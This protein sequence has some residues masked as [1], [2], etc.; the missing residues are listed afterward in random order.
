M[1][2]LLV[3]VLTAVQLLSLFACGGG[4]KK[5][6]PEPERVK[7]EGW[8]THLT[9][10]IITNVAYTGEK[11]LSYTVYM[12]R[13]ETEGC[14]LAVLLDEDV[15]GAS[16]VL[17]SGKNDAIKE[18]AFILNNTHT[19]KRKEWTDSAVPYYG[20]RI[21]QSAGVILPFVVEF[22]TTADTPA[23]D[24][25][26]VYDFL[27]K[28]KNSLVRFNVTV[29]VWDIVLSE[30]KSFA[31]AAGVSGHFIGELDI[32]SQSTF[33][34]YYELLLQHN[35]SAYSIPYDLLDDKADEYMSD[36]R[37]TSFAVGLVVVGDWEDEKI[38]R[39][40][41]KLKSNPVWL[42]KAYFYIIDEPHNEEQ[43]AEY[44]GYC[45]RL[46]TLCPEIPVVAPFYTNIQISGK[47]ED[48]VDAMAGNTMLWC[49]K[50]CL[51]DDAKSYDEFLNYTPEKSFAERMKEFQNEGDVIWSYVCNDPIMPYAQLYIDTPGVVQRLM[52]WQHYQ[53]DIT[54][55]LYWSTNWWGTTEN[56]VNP[57]DTPNNGMSDGKGNITYGEGYL[58]YP[59]KRHGGTVVPSTRLKILRDGID[60]IELFYIAEQVLG[61][62]RV[63]KWVNEATPTLTTY[64]DEER[65][66]EIRKEMGDALEAALKA[67]N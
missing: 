8:T 34:S 49:P 18:S 61:K 54:G 38:L 44:N 30:D 27:D 31:T 52:M 4:G 58:L 6:S 3:F 35:I 48:Q 39:Y 67:A 55:F 46:Q 40:Y 25:E 22:T 7:A 5:P 10:K 60:D 56:T 59:G 57:F 2:K 1:K 23:G 21:N 32:Y 45:E 12:T 62:E 14:Q 29:H 47:K 9:D 28:D 42:E 15:K 37:V 63:M 41:E 24:Y 13:G 36:P 17:S 11:S 16:L 50:L 51:W 66:Y 20:K 33:D 53:R 65:F 64:T 26:Y 19:I 43:I